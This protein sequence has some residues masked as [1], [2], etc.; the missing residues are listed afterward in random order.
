MDEHPTGS[1]KTGWSA[2]ATQIP[3]TA[4]SQSS[5]P[6][7]FKVLKH[8]NTV[9]IADP[10]YGLGVTNC[11]TDYAVHLTQVAQPCPNGIRN[12]HRVGGI[13]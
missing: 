1:P 7:A 8:I 9:A 5:R 2:H 6:K 13:C 4:G 3:F 12:T 10:P 11:K